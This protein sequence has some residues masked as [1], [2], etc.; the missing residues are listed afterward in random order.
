MAYYN[1]PGSGNIWGHIGNLLAWGLSGGR[2][3]MFRR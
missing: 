2:S 1:S 3:C